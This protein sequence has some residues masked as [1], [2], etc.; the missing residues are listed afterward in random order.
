MAHNS[1]PSLH[2]SRVYANVNADFGRDWWDYETLTISSVDNEN[3][4]IIKKVG[5]GKYSE[6]FEGINI[7]TDEKIVIKVRKSYS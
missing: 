7:E 5:K 6:V 2:V 4:E 1:D 3:Y